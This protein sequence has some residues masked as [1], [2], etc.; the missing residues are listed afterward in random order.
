MLWAVPFGIAL[1]IGAFYAVDKGGRAERCTMAVLAMV[2]VQ[3]VM[4]NVFSGHPAPLVYYALFD[5][6][7]ALTL[8][9]SQTSSH[10][11]NWQ[12]IPV[13]LFA[14]MCLAHTVFWAMTTYGSTPSAFAYQSTIAVLAYLQIASVIFAARNHDYARRGG[15]LSGL[16][17]W[18][19]SDSWVYRGS[20]SRKHNAEA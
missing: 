17:Y 14:G 19:L 20:T 13:G 1:C 6:V 8:F 3:T 7:A 15:N 12:W 18:A 11:R 2:W 16:D 5:I 10:G 4:V 9:V